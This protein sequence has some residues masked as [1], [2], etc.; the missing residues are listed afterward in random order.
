MDLLTAYT[1]HTELH[2]ITALPLIST[3]Y[4]SL[5]HPFSLFPACRA[6]I[7]HS[8]A[9]VSNSGDSSASRVQVLSSQPPM[10]N[11]TLNWQLPPGLAAVSHQPPR[12]STEW[13]A[14]T[15]FKITPLHGPHR[16]HPFPLLQL[17]SSGLHNA[18]SYSPIA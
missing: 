7:S 15:V 5:Q 10:Q 9:K 14:P 12:L 8:L 13:V 1:H 2:V 17:T 4:K 16:K 11:S 6:S 3:L 18:I